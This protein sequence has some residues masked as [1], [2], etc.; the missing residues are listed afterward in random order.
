[1]CVPERAHPPAMSGGD[2]LAVM[3]RGAVRGIVN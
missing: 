2:V 3:P 1:L